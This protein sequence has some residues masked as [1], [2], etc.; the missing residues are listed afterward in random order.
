MLTL[1]SDNK[2]PN[3][4]DVYNW[5]ELD[6]RGN[7]CI[8]NEK[9]SHKGLIKFINDHYSSDDKGRWFFQNGPQR[10]FVKLHS[11]PFILSIA[12]ND[13]VIYFKTQTNQVIQQIEQFWLDNNGRLLLSWGQYLGLLSDRD[14]LMMS[15]YIVPVNANG[16]QEFDQISDL[17]IP[18]SFS[19]NK[20][21][22]NLKLN[23]RLY[24]IRPIRERDFSRL[25]NFEPNPAPPVG[26]PDC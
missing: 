8:K 5:L 23:N 14:L 15:D 6:N 25:F 20:I 24:D 4:P 22:F 2:W 19:E 10:V 18:S 12:L 11:T 16:Q 7:W 13:D 21:P 26:S 17:D 1:G 3:V 9:I